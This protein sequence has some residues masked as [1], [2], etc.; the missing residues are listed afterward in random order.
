MLQA[1]D[2]DVR[3]LTEKLAQARNDLDDS[4][5]KYLVQLKQQ[6]QRNK[7]ILSLEQELAGRNALIKELKVCSLVC[8]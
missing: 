2:A 3:Q 7:R 8:A 5:N 1:R 4:Q 6:E